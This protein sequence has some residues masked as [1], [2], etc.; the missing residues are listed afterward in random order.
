MSIQAIR[1]IIE[2]GK[3]QSI[4]TEIRPS[5]VKDEKGNLKPIYCTRVFHYPGNDKFEL[6]FTTYADANGKLPLTKMEIKGHIVFGNPHPLI[7]GAYELDYF[8]SSSFV[9]TPLHD[10]LVQAL[11]QL[12]PPAGASPWQKDVSQEVKGKAV[13]AF[14]LEAGKDFNEY[15][16]IFVHADHLYNGARNIDGRPFDKPENRPTNLQIPLVRA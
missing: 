16:L 7:S 4:S 14:G 9:I 10:G 3:W 5:I 13:P 2:G 15:D 8:G 12:P 6:T 11:N 1:N